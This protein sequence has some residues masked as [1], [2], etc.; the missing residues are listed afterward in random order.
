MLKKYSKEMVKMFKVSILRE[1]FK[2][3][4]SNADNESQMIDSTILRA[5]QNSTGEIKKGD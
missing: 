5:H 4:V 2:Y 3:L 1:F